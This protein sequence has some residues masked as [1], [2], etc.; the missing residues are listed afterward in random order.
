MATVARFNVT[1]VK[2]TA[3]LHPEAVTFTEAGIPENRRFFLVDARGELFSGSDFGPLVQVRASIGDNGELTCAFPGGNLVSGPSDDVGDR[4][5]V[6][7]YGRPVHARE[8]RGP[9]AAAFSDHAGAAVRLLRTDR[10]GD[11]AD[12]LPLTI[13]GTASVADLGRRGGYA[14]ELDPRRF[15]INVELDGTDPFEEDTWS[16]RSVA[17]GDAVIRVAGQIPRCVVTTQN[18]GTGLQDWNTLK[19]IAAFRSPMPD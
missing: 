14:G 7:F 17:M 16:G 6:D 9:F 13:V 4:L 10:D 3:L 1:P 12:V 5:L 11:G 18:P 8:V 15:R 2:G 19:Q